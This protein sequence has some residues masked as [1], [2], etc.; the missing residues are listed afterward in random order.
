MSTRGA[1]LRISPVSALTLAGVSLVGVAAFLWPLVLTTAGDDGHATDA[2]WVFVLLLPLLLL[3][4][5]TQLSSGGLDAK[6]V[7]LLGVLSGVSALLRPLSGGVTGIQ[8]MF[9][10]LVP[11]GRVFGPGFGFLL[12]N[13][14]M[15]ASAALTGGG[16]PWLPF[17]M[18]AAGW[19]GLGAGL[20]PPLRGRLELLLLSG[21]GFAAGIAYGFVMNLWFWPFAA[22]GTGTA[23]A[24]TFVAGAPLTDNLHRWLAFSTTTSLSFDLPRGF[25]TAVAVLLVG[26]PVLS[27]LRRASRRAAFEGPVIFVPAATA[28][29]AGPRGEARQDGA[30]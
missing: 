18:L 7:A 12:G 1:A 13:V 28:S 20:L 6:A 3:I 9:F 8:L 23:S 26:R 21:Y 19:I 27:A 10:L 22:S 14:A 2:P 29:G 15:F 17:Q 11:A 16:G 30:S 4:A 5:V 25:A 24:V